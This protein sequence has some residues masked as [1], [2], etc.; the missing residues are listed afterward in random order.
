MTT[1]MEILEALNAESGPITPKALATKMEASRPIVVAALNSLFKAAALNREEGAYA[2][3][4]IG[5]RMLGVAPTPPVP[6]TGT[7]ASDSDS[8]SDS[9]SDS[10]NESSEEAA[11]A[12][13][14]QRF[15]LLGTKVG[16]T[17]NLISLTADHV[18][19]GGDFKDIK[20]VQDA[21]A[22]MGIRSDLSMRWLNSW[23]SYLQ[24]H[25]FPV[26]NA[27]APKL[28]ADGK[29]I[30]DHAKGGRDY[31]LDENDNPV[32]VG[33]GLGDLPHKDALE[34][35]KIRG[36]RGRATSRSGEGQLSPVEML[37][38]LIAAIQNLDSFRNSSASAPRPSYIMKPKEDGSWEAEEVPEGKPMIVG[39]PTAKKSQTFVYD[40]ATGVVTEAEAGRPVFIGMGQD[41]PSQP[42]KTILVDKATGTKEEVPAGQPIIIFQQ[43]SAPQQ[44]A[45]QQFTPIQLTGTDGKPIIMDLN[46]YIRLEEFKGEEHRREESHKTKQ[47]LA[48]GFKDLI[49][50]AASAA[51]RMMESRTTE[52]QLATTD[53]KLEAYE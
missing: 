48:Q 11:K 12:T 29:T 44:I 23:R 20:W 37:S 36:G 46:T 2:I 5:R 28:E 19:N 33:E 41:N 16:V 7:I 18:W 4:D 15:C 3:N 38:Q 21:M 9:E 8:D 52:K 25:G 40:K 24:H 31:I 50:K 6:P 10:E 43:P 13:E 26:S 47:D 42:A 27:P 1:K 45:P 53:K 51:E 34:L 49:K 35:S 17:K 39:S 32:Y 30:S 22:E 14:Y